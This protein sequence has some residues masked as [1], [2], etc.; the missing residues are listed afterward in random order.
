MKNEKPSENHRDCQLGFAVLRLMLGIHMLGRGMV[1][2]PKLQEFASGT[3]SAFSDTF[4]PGGFV[5]VYAIMIVVVET[6]L[7]ILLILGWH[8]SKALAVMGLLMC[9]L[10]FGMIL[11]ENFGTAGNILVYCFAI[12]FLLFHTRYDAFGIDG[13]KKRKV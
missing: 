13:R 5:Y 4:L 10:A 7:G 11:Q 1:R 2:F 8:T 9:T 3:A 12:S 6:V